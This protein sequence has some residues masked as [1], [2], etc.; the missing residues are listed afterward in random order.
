LAPRF[1]I[2]T[3]GIDTSFSQDGSMDDM[4]A[5]SYLKKILVRKGD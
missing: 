2:K 5:D 1:Y 3:R 4:M